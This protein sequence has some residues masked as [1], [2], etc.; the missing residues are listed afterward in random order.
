MFHPE[1]TE[2]YIEVKITA[3]EA[4]LLKVLRKYSFGKIM[5]HK[6]NGSLVRIEP[7]ESILINETEGLD[8]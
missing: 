3:K 8:L 4:H 6:I 7:S 5:I 1:V 2:K